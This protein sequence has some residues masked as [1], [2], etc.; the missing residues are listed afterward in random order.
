MDYDYVTKLGKFHDKFRELEDYSLKN[1][2]AIKPSNDSDSNTKYAFV[3]VFHEVTGADFDTNY[4]VLVSLDYETVTHHNGYQRLI[5]EGFKL[6]KKEG[7]RPPDERFL[8]LIEIKKLQDK[9]FEPKYTKKEHAIFHQ[10]MIDCQE[11][12]EDRAAELFEERAIEY[13]KRHPKT[14]LTTDD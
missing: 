4:Q 13:K 7:I 1:I 11:L 5:T 8:K 3:N 9:L 10:Y 6:A 2:M 14:R 12:G